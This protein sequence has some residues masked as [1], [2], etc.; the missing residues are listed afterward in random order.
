M[1]NVSY[2]NFATILHTEILVN[3]TEGNLNNLSVLTIQNT[4][5]IRPDYIPS[6]TQDVSRT[7]VLFS[8][9]IPNH[10][11]CFFVLALNVRIQSM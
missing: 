9:A 4:K 5:K 2:L 6:F 8:S 1:K 11:I 10:R 7:L 3:R